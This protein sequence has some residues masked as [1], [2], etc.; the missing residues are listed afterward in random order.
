MDGVSL[1]P[2]F[3]KN[4]RR[5]LVFLGDRGGLPSETLSRQWAEH[6]KKLTKCTYPGACAERLKQAQF[7]EV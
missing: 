2:W 3:N 4:I 1:L 5:H 6:S 7:E